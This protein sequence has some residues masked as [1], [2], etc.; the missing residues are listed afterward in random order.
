MIYDRLSSHRP[1]RNLSP[2]FAAAF[3]FLERAAADCPL[4][5]V[6]IIPGE[7]WATNVRKA[8]L[9]AEKA[10]FEYHRRF[11]DLHFCPAGSDQFGWQGGIDGLEPLGPFEPEKDFGQLAGPPR[12]FLP[13][14]GD[15]FAIL[16]PGEPHSP[17]IGEGEIT[18]ICIKV[19][20]DPAPSPGAFK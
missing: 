1:Y 11:A 5:R 9:P 8:A 17:F 20:M 18:R 19:L 14:H 4:G 16:F 12:Q 7:V 2:R 3:D 15:R 10:K 6:E 13:L